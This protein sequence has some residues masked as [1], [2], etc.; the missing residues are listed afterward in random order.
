MLQDISPTSDFALVFRILSLLN[1]EFHE[2]KAI[3]LI[4]LDRKIIEKNND[5]ENDKE[6]DNEQIK[7]KRLFKTL[8][9]KI[10]YQKIAEDYNY[11]ESMNKY[12]EEGV[13]FLYQYNHDLN[14]DCDLSLEDL[15]NEI[16]KKS[17]DNFRDVHKKMES[18]IKNINSGK[19]KKN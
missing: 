19:Y 16:Q 1:K 7:E 11:R 10:I 14:Y 2:N 4:S 18:L 6:N 9:N 12:L 15:K 17:D 5:T 13:E 3:G 8:E